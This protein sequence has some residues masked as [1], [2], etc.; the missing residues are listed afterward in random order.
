MDSQLNEQLSVSNSKFIK[1]MQELDPSCDISEHIRSLPYGQELASGSF[2]KIINKLD[3]DELVKA[4]K[5][6]VFLDMDTSDIVEHILSHDD[7]EDFFL[8]NEYF[9]KVYKL[10]DDIDCIVAN[11][12][13]KLYN[14]RVYDS[15]M[16][17][18]E[19]SSQLGD[20]TVDDAEWAIT[21][22]HKVTIRTIIKAIDNGKR[23]MHS[24]LVDNYSEHDDEILYD[25]DID[26]LIGALRTAVFRNIETY[27][28]VHYIF[29]HP[30]SDDLFVEYSK[31]RDI[32]YFANDID[33]I[34]KREII[35]KHGTPP[36]NGYIT[37]YYF[38]CKRKFIS[39]EEE[40][41]EEL[42]EELE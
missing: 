16:L 30:D 2:N 17:G 28:L 18:R 35:R 10:A 33:Y 25:M 39:D 37:G 42:E 1:A 6:A 12:I 34:L 3:M 27:S 38:N 14:G 22:G 23:K 7:A 5:T 13:I 32:Y 21:H 26:E 19:Y 24:L 36:Y 20:F 8:K 31:C 29:T 9:D 41:E 4:L 15:E 40:S 11:S